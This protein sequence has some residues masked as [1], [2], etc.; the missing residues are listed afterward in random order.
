[1]EMAWKRVP[2]LPSKTNNR[3]DWEDHDLYQDYY[4][5]GIVR[6]EIASGRY[7]KK[8]DRPR[9]KAEQTPKYKK[10]KISHN[11]SSSV[12]SDP[13]VK[14]DTTERAESDI[15]MY[16]E[17]HVE[18]SD[19]IMT[20]IINNDPPCG[21][22]YNDPCALMMQDIDSNGN[23][24]PIILENVHDVAPLRQ[25]TSDYKQSHGPE[26]GEGNEDENP[27]NMVLKLQKAK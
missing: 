9:D 18:Q 21:K 22:A 5:D 6:T 15:D 13:S 19:Q 10:D 25:I 16:E 23:E 26:K 7:P 4:Y 14:T 12:K 20:K 2:T 27:L 11:R 1:M 24:I 8:R 3:V 17:L